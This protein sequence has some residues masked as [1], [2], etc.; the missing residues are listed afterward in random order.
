MRSRQ[1]ESPQP[2]AT[3][4]RRQS[5]SAAVQDRGGSHAQRVGQWRSVVR[6]DDM[7]SHGTVRQQPEVART[8]ASRDSPGDGLGPSYAATRARHGQERPQRTQVRG[9]R[10]HTRSRVI[11]CYARILKQHGTAD[12]LNQGSVHSTSPTPTLSEGYRNKR[13]DQRS[14][15]EED[16]R[17]PTQ[18]SH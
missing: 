7:S 3:R 2:S 16:T 13:Q 5:N 6:C 10:A 17:V 4:R 1:G 12:L 15:E 11:T 8:Q 9:D 14:T 18:T